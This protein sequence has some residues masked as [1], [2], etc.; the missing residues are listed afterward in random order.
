MSLLSSPPRRPEVIRCFLLPSCTPE[1][2]RPR[3]SENRSSLQETIQ[4][5]LLLD[6]ATQHH[7]KTDYLPR[8]LDTEFESEINTPDDNNRAS[9]ISAEQVLGVSRGAGFARAY[10]T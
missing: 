1:E 2:A 9:P 7:V 5:A 3:L 6:V 10:S 4:K 8:T